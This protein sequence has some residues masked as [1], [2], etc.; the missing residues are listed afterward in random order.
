M[1]G[2]G[3]HRFVGDEG[4]DGVGLLRVGLLSFPVYFQAK[5]WCASRPRQGPR[6][7]G[8]PSPVWLNK[9]ASI[10]T[11]AIHPGGRIQASGSPIDLV[12]GE[13]LCDLLL[14]HEL[15]VRFVLMLYA[16]IRRFEAW[17]L[18]FC[19]HAATA[20][21]TAHAALSDYACAPWDSNPEPAD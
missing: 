18:K 4:L 17:K 14:K 8:A 9:E 16:A 1:R 12:D 3:S 10:T 21:P 15:C 11:G 19:Y 13:V 7:P 5:R 6:V 2:S 20:Q